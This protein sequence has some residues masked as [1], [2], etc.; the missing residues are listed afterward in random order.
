[1]VIQPCFP[2]SGVAHLANVIPLER[3][4][5]P[6]GL[7]FLGVGEGGW[8]D[9]GCMVIGVAVGGK[10]RRVGNLGCSGKGREKTVG[11]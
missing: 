11:D 5:R 9:C 3:E 10:R 2:R 8:G 4:P 6:L 1:M 7:Y